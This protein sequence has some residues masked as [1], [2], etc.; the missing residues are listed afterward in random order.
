MVG[1]GNGV[2]GAAQASGEGGEFGPFGAFQGEKDFVEIA[3]TVFAAA[4]GGFDFW[5]DGK[6]FENFG[7][8]LVEEGIGDGEEAHEKKI[9]AFFVES[10]R[11]GEFLAEVGAGESGANEFGRLAGTHG[12]DGENGNPAAEFTFAKQGDGFANTMDFGAQGE[13]RGVQIT[14]EAIEQGRLLFE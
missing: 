12:D 1:V 7:Y 6:R 4:E 8:G 2:F 14:Q 9:G 5:I 3:I 11:H 13:G 10:S